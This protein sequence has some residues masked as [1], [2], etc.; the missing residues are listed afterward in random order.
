MLSDCLTLALTFYYEAELKHVEVD[1]YEKVIL[2]YGQL[3]KS[4]SIYPI[5]VSLKIYFVYFVCHLLRHNG[6]WS[7]QCS[8]LLSV[9][10]NSISKNK[11]P[12]TMAKMVSYSCIKYEANFSTSTH[13]IGFLIQ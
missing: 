11:F 1:F 10:T 7:F 6:E 12:D 5:S 2:K 9:V 3:A 4:I 13:K 8:S